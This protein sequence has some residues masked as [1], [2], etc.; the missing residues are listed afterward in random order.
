MS[1]RASR[2][3]AICGSRCCR[4]ADASISALSSKLSLLVRC[5]RLQPDRDGPPKGGHHVPYEIGSS[6]NAFR[7]FAEVTILLYYSR[8]IGTY[9]GD[10]DTFP[11]RRPTLAAR[12]SRRVGALGGPA[13]RADLGRSARTEA[14]RA[15]HPGTA[16]AD[17]SRDARRRYG[18]RAPV[19]VVPHAAGRQFLVRSAAALAVGD[20][21]RADAARLAPARNAAPAPRGLLAGM[22]PRRPRRH[23]VQSDQHAA[24]HGDIRESP[25]APWPRG[26][27]QDHDR[28]PVG[29]RAAQS[30]GRGGRPQ[31]RI[32]VGA[33][34]AAAGAAAEAGLVVGRSFV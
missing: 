24:G 20:L 2:S 30:A 10:V 18:G 14:A 15:A 25:H 22:A 5:V 23:P 16:R 7:K 32:G 34:P 6:L 12:F 11:A 9:A 17:L 3:W 28:G 31:G 27:R 13:R 1:R 33:G 21:C 29:N 26:V 8:E 4:R 19:P